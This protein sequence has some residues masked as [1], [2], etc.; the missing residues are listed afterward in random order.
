MPGFWSLLHMHTHTQ[1]MNRMAAVAAGLKKGA[2]FITFT[3]R[4]PSPH[5]KVSEME[6]LHD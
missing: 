4:L 1:L 3:K 2:F 6:W 5:F